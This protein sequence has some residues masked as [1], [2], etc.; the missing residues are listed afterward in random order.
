MESEFEVL[1]LGKITYTQFGNARETDLDLFVNS[2]E[3]TPLQRIAIVDVWKRHPNKQNWYMLT[4]F[5]IAFYFPYILLCYC[6]I[7]IQ[8]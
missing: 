3:L 4:I 7:V 6:V 1:N 5:N 8:A 2:M